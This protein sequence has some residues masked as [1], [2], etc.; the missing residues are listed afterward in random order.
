MRKLRSGLT[1]L[2]TA[3]A[4]SVA[5]VSAA[6][7]SAAAPTCTYTAQSLALPAGTTSAFVT[8]TDGNTTFAGPGRVS[9]RNQWIVWHEGVPE[10]LPTPFSGFVELNGINATGDAVGLVSPDDGIGLPLWYH[11]GAFQP[12]SV[13]GT[14]TA[15]LTGIN[16]AG[17]IVGTIIRG[18]VSRVAVWRAGHQAD[19]P[20]VLSTPDGFWPAYPQVADDGSVAVFGSIGADGYGY[21]WAPDGTRSALTPPLGGTVS[22]VS[23]I[24]GHR[25]I[26]SAQGYGAV[27]WDLSGTLLGTP[28]TPTTEGLAVTSAG[29]VLMSYRVPNERTTSPIVTSPDA[30]WQH[31]PAPPNSTNVNANSITEAGVVGGSYTDSATG[32]V[33]PVQWKCAP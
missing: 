18:G 9:G 27:E 29:T 20:V 13:F 3:V 33:R 6:T 24:R 31:L 15:H 2:A 17:D 16:A 28:G 4:A 32:Q 1:A 11:A 30:P 14:D 10:M 7:P 23:G 25:I 21:V 12:A 8:A 22:R 5:L 19:P 26:G